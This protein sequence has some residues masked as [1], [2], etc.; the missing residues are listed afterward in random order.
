M[1]ALPENAPITNRFS[2]KG[3]MRFDTETHRFDADVNPDGTVN[4]SW[5]ITWKGKE[6][7]L[8]TGCRGS[9]G[10]QYEAGAEFLYMLKRFPMRELQVRGES[11]A[12]DGK[13][14]TQRG[15]SLRLPIDTESPSGT[16]R[17]VTIR[18]SAADFPPKISRSVE[19]HSAG[20]NRVNPYLGS[21][22]GNRVNPYLGSPLVGVLLSPSVNE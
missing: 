1:F 11:P 3:W 21:Q 5:P 20:G 17:K 22:L 12:R 18:C 19:S 4:L 6:P 15:N 14:G 8:T 13:S 7:K 16:I 2:F 10:G 9:Q